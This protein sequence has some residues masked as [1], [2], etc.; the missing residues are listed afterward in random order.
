MLCGGGV[1][2][3]CV[4]VVCSG[5]VCCCCCV[6]LLCG[7]AMQVVVPLY[8]R[9]NLLPTTMLVI[10]FTMPCPKPSFPYQFLQAHQLMFYTFTFIHI[11]IFNAQAPARPTRRSKS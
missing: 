1:W 8:T 9:H 4:V 3:W 10:I 7:N 2:W 5:G 11:H 6:L